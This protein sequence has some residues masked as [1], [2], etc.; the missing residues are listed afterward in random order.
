MTRLLIK[1]FCF[2]AVLLSGAGV[3]VGS[4][5]YTA[6]NSERRYEKMLRLKQ[7]E[8]NLYAVQF[9]ENPRKLKYAKRK[10]IIWPT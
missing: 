2:V 10:G 1:L 8:F 5:Y 6:E 9:F 7:I 4:T 3:V